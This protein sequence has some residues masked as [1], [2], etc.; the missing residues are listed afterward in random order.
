MLA[1]GAHSMIH[2]LGIAG[3][4][5][6]SVLS[7]E[8]EKNDK[9]MRP[10]DATRDGFVVGEGG[11]IVV[12]ESLKHARARGA[13]IW[14]ELRGYAS[15]HEAYHLTDTHTPRAGPLSSACAGRCARPN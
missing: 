11:A 13:D 8:N 9:A 7:E 5:R 1:G 14:G 4:H 12:L 10:F 3:L 2:P 6:L 15:A